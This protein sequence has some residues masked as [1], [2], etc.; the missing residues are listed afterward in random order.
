MK[1]KK[2]F[3]FLLMALGLWQIAFP[4]TFFHLLCWDCSAMVLSDLISG[5]ALFVLG[6]LTYVS[7]YPI[8]AAWLAGLVG[9]W[10]QCAPVLF[11]ANS[12]MIYLNDTLVGALAIIFCF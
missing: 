3:A 4:L 7:F 5:F 6:V 9:L 1:D 2:L 11:W 12:P 10:M 8:P